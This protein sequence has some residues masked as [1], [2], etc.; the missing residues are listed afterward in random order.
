MTKKITIEVSAHN[1]S[2]RHIGDQNLKTARQKTN[3]VLDIWTMNAPLRLVCKITHNGF[4][5]GRTYPAS[6]WALNGMILV[7]DG[8]RE[9]IYTTIEDSD[10]FITKWFWTMGEWREQQLKEIG[11]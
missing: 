7:A 4:V 9:L 11:I 2:G 8:N 10:Y 1:N 6:I 5:K 3:R